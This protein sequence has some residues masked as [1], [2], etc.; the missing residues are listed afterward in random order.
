MVNYTLLSGRTRDG[1]PPSVCRCRR[2]G[3]GSPDRSPTFGRY[4]LRPSTGRLPAA[5]KINA[6]SENSRPETGLKPQDKVSRLRCPRSVQGHRSVIV[7]GVLVVVFRRDNVARP[8]FFLRK[9]DI[10]LVASLDA[11][12]TV[13][14]GAAGI[15]RPPLWAGIRRRT[16][17]GVARWLSAVLHV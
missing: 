7:F 16:R 11:S 10:S 12:G 15:R 2:N 17:F 3:P 9:R 14:F 6:A 8:S 13:L 1:R 4:G 5:S